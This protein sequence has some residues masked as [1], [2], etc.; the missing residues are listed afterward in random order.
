MRMMYLVSVVA[1]ALLLAATSVSSQSK[2]LTLE[3]A[4]QIA[5]ERNVSV[6]QAQNNVE[7]AQ[8]GVLS[9]TGSYLPTLSATGGWS[10]NQ[11]EGPV[12]LGGVQ[13]SN[14]KT[15]TNYFNTNLNLNYT[16]F[17]GFAR[18]GNYTR[19]S[20]NAIATEQSAARTRQSII[21]QVERA[22]V[23]VLRNEQLVKVSEENLKRDQRQLERIAESNRVG[24]LSRADVY[25]QQSQVAADELSVINAQNNYNKA[26][27]DL[28][29]LIGLDVNDDYVIADPTI[30]TEIAQS[31]LDNAAAQYNDFRTLAQRALEKRPDYVGAMESVRS[32]EGGVSAARSGYFPSVSAFA[33]YGFSNRDLSRLTENKSVSWG[34]NLRWT[35]FDGFSTNENLQ[36][37]YVQKKNAELSLQQTERNINVEVKKALL[38][39]E[40]ARKAY[41]VSQKGL[42]SAIEDR[43][44]AE[45]RYN[46]G[47]GTLLDLLIANAGLV[48]AQANKVNAVYDFIIAKRNVE[49]AIGERTY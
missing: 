30:A 19:A 9:A 31:D 33:G 49:Y 18:E 25:R 35:L 10:R 4:R 45:E 29:A 46:L 1:G 44:I 17:N 42:L 39:L 27:A 2:T 13:I 47:A 20:A 28:L 34:L 12:F 26:K 24:A 23:N 41:E 5:L 6:A 32:A 14:T 37:A 15:V 22:Y 43:K 7:A 40:A 21:F 11:T 38:D 36:A 3:Q 16:I 48:S 8:A